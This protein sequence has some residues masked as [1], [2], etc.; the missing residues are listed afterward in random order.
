MTTLSRLG[1]HSHRHRFAIRGDNG[2]ILL[3]SDDGANTGLGSRPDEL[4]PDRFWRLSEGELGR[5]VQRE[6]NEQPDGEQPS[7]ADLTFATRV[8]ANS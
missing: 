4:Y 2:T 5:Y 6:S 8:A 7:G 3:R 1:A